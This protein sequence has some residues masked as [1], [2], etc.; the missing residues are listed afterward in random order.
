MQTERDF[1]SPESQQVARI[2]I[3]FIVYSLRNESV[4]NGADMAKWLREVTA[5]S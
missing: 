5:C 2:I 1:E 4:Y 3:Y